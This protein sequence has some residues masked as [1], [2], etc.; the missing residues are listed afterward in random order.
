[1]NYLAEN[2]LPIWIGGAVLLTLTGVVYCA[3]A[4]ARSAR[5]HAGGGR[6]HRGAVWS[7]S[8]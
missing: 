2:A 6:R 7:S 1:M 5:R 8:G 3:A 4:I